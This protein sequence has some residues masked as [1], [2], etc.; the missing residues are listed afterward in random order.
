VKITWKG[1][2]IQF[3]TCQCALMSFSQENGALDQKPNLSFSGFIDIFH[4]YDFNQPKSIQRQSFFYNHNR[5]NEFNLNLGLLKFEIEQSKYRANIGLQTGTYV[6]DNM[7]SE[8]GFLKNIFEAN[9]GIS[10][11]KKNNI[12][13]DAG[14]LP[15]HIGFESAISIDNFTLSRSL[16]AEN[17]PYFL[18]GMKLT[19]NPSDNLEIAGLF[20]NGWQRIQR[21]EGNSFPS[22]GTQFRYTFSKS[23]I[24]NWSTFIGSD[25]IDI[26]RRIRYFNN[27]FGK[28]RLSNKLEFITGFDLGIQQIAKGSF[29]YNYWFS[30]TLISKYDINNNWKAAIRVEYY[31]DKNSIIISTISK[32]GIQTKGISLNFDYAPSR[33][34]ICRI[35]GRWLNN[36]DSI[37]ESKNGI[38]RNNFFIGS[39]IAIKMSKTKLNSLNN[40]NKL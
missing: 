5:H 40:K 30:P 35:E 25:D 21:L 32:N 29:K 1:I 8:P 4:V 17:S 3:F 22:F 39:S 28:L 7:V 38:K 11:N 9:I 19:I 16:S 26:K 18:T 33:I 20:V 2:I 13:L 10:L 37:F 27:F 34:L 36:V 6:N 14:I 23:I 12:W 24:L 15:S 31:N